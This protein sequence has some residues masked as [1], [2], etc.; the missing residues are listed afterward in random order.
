MKVNVSEM[1]RSVMMGEPMTATQLLEKIGNKTTIRRIRGILVKMVETGHLNKHGTCS[2]YSYTLTDKVVRK[3]DLA[4]R[5]PPTKMDKLPYTLDD[6]LALKDSLDFS[7]RQR[8]QLIRQAVKLLPMR[9][10]HI[11]IATGIERRHV[12]GTLSDMR[13]RGYVRRL[14]DG[15]YEFVSDPKNQAVREVRKASISQAFSGK[16]VRAEKVDPWKAMQGESVESFLANGGKIDYSETPIKFERL[17]HEEIVSK[18]G[19]V[20]I[21]YQSPISA[22]LSPSGRA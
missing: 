9:P 19:V 10:V 14:D 15:R 11:S 2:P 12:S 8:S 6:V 5:E 22:R 16:T 4:T 13:M 20:S 7:A 18:V 3:Y 17:T 1:I 21:G